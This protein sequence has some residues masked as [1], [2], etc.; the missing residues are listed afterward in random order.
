[1]T[2]V[3]IVQ[4]EGQ[5]LA[6]SE[7]FAGLGYASRGKAT[8]DAAKTLD[9]TPPNSR[10]SDSFFKAAG[11]EIVTAE[12][13]G[14]TSS[15]RQIMNQADYFYFSGHGEHYNNVVHNGD[16]NGGIGPS[17]VKG[18]W[19]RDLDCVIIAGCSVLDINDYN[20]IFPG[21]SHTL[22]PGKAW[23][24]TGPKHLLGYA[25]QAPGDAGGAPTR[26]IQSWIAKRAAL[27]DVEAWMQANKESHAW[28]ACAI[29]KGERYV[30]FY[31]GLKGL[32]KKKTEVNKEDW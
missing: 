17:A 1:M 28:N 7:A 22:S 15:R 10:P 18:Y 16:G 26:I 12:F 9:S 3:D 31:R 27:G 5:S 6:D 4:T 21:E 23:E 25:A 30:Y 24:Q 13:G 14:A 11:C 2:I 8:L 20:G 29:E 19:G 32:Y